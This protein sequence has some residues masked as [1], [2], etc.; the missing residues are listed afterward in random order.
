MTESEVVIRGG[1][2]CLGILDKQ[3]YG[4]TQYSLAHLFCELYGGEYCCKL[5]SSLS[6]LFTNFLRSE[7]F[8]LGVEDILVTKPANLERTR[9]MKETELVGRDCATQGVGLKG[10]VTEEE[11]RH[12]LEG[13]HRASAKVPKR[14]MDIDRGFKSALNPATNDRCA[15]CGAGALRV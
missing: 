4:A 8:T 3:H 15:Y 6:K 7:G 2:L 1:E 9:I 14:R 13:A 11:L 10:E 5:L 12:Q